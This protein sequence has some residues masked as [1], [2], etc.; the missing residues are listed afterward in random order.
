MNV[1]NPWRITFVTNMDD[2]NLHCL[3]CEEHSR[4]SDRQARRRAQGLPPRRMDFALVRRLMDG[5]ADQ[6]PRE[7]IPST[8]GEPLL[9]RHF[10]E[11]LAL[12]RQ[13]GTRLNLTTN[14][15]FPGRGARAWAEAIVPVGSDVKISINGVR[16][17]TQAT[18]M[19]GAPLAEILENARQFIAVRDHVAAAGGNY[20][21]MTFQVTYLETNI[22]ELPDLVRLAAGMGVDRVKGHHVWTHGFPELERLSLRRDVAAIRHFNR[23][24]EATTRAARERLRGDGRPVKLDN[25]FALPEGGSQDLAPGGECPFLGQEAWINWDGRFDPCCAPDEQRRSLGSFGNIEEVG[26]T[27][28][29][30]GEAYRRLCRE[31]AS[32]PLCRSCNMRR[33]KA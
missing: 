11:L 13:R 32:Y 1:P 6:P 7:I 31:Y 20:C 23:V 10:E 21:S 5:L 33:P 2:C 18:I 29:W 15:T 25:L 14:G 19:P 24:V 12:C 8:M 26:F 22:D 9:Y 30:R 28:I 17:E 3:M 27:A 16:P 4:L